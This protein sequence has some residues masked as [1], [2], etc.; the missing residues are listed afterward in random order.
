MR[1]NPDGE[2]NWILNYQDH[3][4]KWISLRS[5]KRK[6]AVEVASTLI[7]IF[8]TLGAPCNLQSDNGIEFTK[9]LLLV[10]LNQ[11]WSSTKIIHGKPRYPKS[12]G[13]VANKRVENIQ[14]VC[15]INFNTQ[16]EKVAYLKNTTVHSVCKNSPYRILYNR[17]PPQ[18]IG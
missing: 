14:Q 6:C 2:N 5:L 15:L 10:T 13:S 11:L 7:S 18:R 1:T 9:N 8:Y 16:L 4:T 3:F 12:Q 17:D